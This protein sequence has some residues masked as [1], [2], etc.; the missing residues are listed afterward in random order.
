MPDFPNFDFLQSFKLLRLGTKTFWAESRK[1]FKSP[2]RKGP[3]PHCGI[4][5]TASKSTQYHTGTTCMPYK[6]QC[7]VHTVPLPIGRLRIHGESVMSRNTYLTNSNASANSKYF[8]L[9]NSDRKDRVDLKT[10]KKI[11]WHILFEEFLKYE[12]EA[13][14]CFGNPPWQQAQVV[15]LSAANWLNHAT[16]HQR[17]RQTHGP[18]ILIGMCREH[19]ALPP[20]QLTGYQSLDM[21]A[22][23]IFILAKIWFLNKLEKNL[24]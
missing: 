2:E 20:P 12:G 4:C 15:E 3:A 10:E 13:G 23:N 11:S 21:N 8:R 6:L 24:A 18:N 16:H 5:N 22:Q 9:R 7:T 14:R 1:D 19:D 17:Y